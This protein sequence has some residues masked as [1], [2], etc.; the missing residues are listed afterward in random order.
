MGI[1][2]RRRQEP[3]CPQPAYAQP[4]SPQPAPTTMCGLIHAA[5]QSNG[6]T[7]RLIAITIVAFLGL[8]LLTYMP[9]VALEHVKGV[10]L[11]IA[12]PTGIV[13]VAGILVAATATITRRTRSNRG[14]SGSASDS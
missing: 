9:I 11:R 1:G 7:C 12:L 6:E 13:S 5:I 14:R 10:T 2:K 4:A 3:A 8:A